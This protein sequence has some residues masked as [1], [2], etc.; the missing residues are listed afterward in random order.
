MTFYEWIRECLQWEAV[1]TAPDCQ[2]MIKR[3][4]EE[5]KKWKKRE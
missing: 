2:K 5:I 3:V 1:Q 4:M